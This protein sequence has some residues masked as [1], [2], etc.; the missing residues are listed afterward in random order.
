[1]PAGFY[2]GGIPFGIQVMAP[3]GRDRELLTM[4]GSIASVI[5]NNSS[6]A[7]ST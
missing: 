1:M 7:C 4:A 5:T 6:A 2:P 3:Q